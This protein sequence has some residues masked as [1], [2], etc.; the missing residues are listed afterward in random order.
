M[1]NP[2]KNPQ[3]AGKGDGPGHI[4][5][6]MKGPNPGKVRKQGPGLRHSYSNSDPHSQPQRTGKKIN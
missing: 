3:P 2:Y 6:Y 4:G 5:Q 1:P